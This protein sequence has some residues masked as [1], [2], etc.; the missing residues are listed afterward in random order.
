VGNWPTHSAK[1]Q[2][3]TVRAHCVDSEIESKRRFWAVERSGSTYQ[4][5]ATAVNSANIANRRQQ[6]PTADQQNQYRQQQQQAAIPANNNI[7]QQLA[8]RSNNDNSGELGANK[9]Q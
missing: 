7:W 6:G 2:V 4:Q 8:I 5:L 3:W 9:G 1:P